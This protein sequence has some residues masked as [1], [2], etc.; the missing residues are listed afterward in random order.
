M[1]EID[2]N[3]EI[4]LNKGF[5]SVVESILDK[6]TLEEQM[7]IVDIWINNRMV[8]GLIHEY[9]TE[10]IY[11]CCK[12][13]IE[14]IIDKNEELPYMPLAGYTKHDRVWYAFEVVANEIVLI[15]RDTIEMPR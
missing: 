10:K 9:Q 4:A 14:K 7:N 5:K 8:D 15:R 12:K 11:N 13:E 1:N 3:L 6:Y 2:W